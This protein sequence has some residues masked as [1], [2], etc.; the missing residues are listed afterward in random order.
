MLASSRR[1]IVEEALQPEQAWNFGTSVTWKFNLKDS[2]SYISADYYYTQ[3]E[4]RVVVDLETWREVRFYNLDGESY[5]NSMQV[6][7]GT[8]PIPR[9]EL[10][11]AYKYYDVRTTYS[12]Q[13]K[14]QPLIPRNRA[15]FTA[16]WMHRSKRWRIDGTIQ[17]VGTSRVPHI[18]GYI[19][20]PVLRSV[21]ADYFLAHAQ[22]TR[23]RK[24]WEFYLGSDN[25]LGYQQPE[26]IIS[27][28]NPFGPDFD[29]SLVWGRVMG[30]NL[31][32]GIRYKI[33]Q[34]PQ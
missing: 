21:S 27:P 1:V 12:G 15:Y 24:R 31:Y 18:P 16:A 29:A 23:V 3:F 9:L 7:F 20:Q 17:W 2:E 11:A 28:D 5:A 30:R 32:G 10:K 26:P 14:R 4:N 33:K 6:E 22:I 34:K 13:L 25:L 8:E 19:D